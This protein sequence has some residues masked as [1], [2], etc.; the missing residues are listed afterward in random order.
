M[1][2]EAPGDSSVRKVSQPVS[3]FEIWEWGTCKDPKVASRRQEG[4]QLTASKELGTT[5]LQLH[6][7]KLSQHQ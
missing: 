3:S 2:E 7:T 4:P 5:V 6:R 1:M